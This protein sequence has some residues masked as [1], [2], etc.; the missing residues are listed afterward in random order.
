MSI[1][2][3]T[4]S[5]PRP[6]QWSLLRKTLIAFPLV[7][8]LAAGWSWFTANRRVQSQ[9]DALQAQGLPATAG[10]LNAFYKVPDGVPDR[11]QEWVKAIDALMAAS[12]KQ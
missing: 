7:L 10:E 9:L 3:D 2:P 4:P 12:S 1:D 11:T 6:A 5:Q 8:F